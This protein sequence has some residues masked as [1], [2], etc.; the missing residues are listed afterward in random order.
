MKILVVCAVLLSGCA[1]V[2]PLV[3]DGLEKAAEAA[4]AQLRLNLHLICN[5]GT[6]GAWTRYFG[7]R[8]KE[9]AGW[10]QLCLRQETE[11][12]LDGAAQ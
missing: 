3:Q 2:A 1:Q 5:G 10:R 7:T 6:T 11:G 4:D 9:A 12:I 8:P